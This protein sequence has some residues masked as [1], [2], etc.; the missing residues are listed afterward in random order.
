MSSSITTTPN[1]NTWWKHEKIDITQFVVTE[2]ATHFRLQFRV[3][4]AS[5]TSSGTENCAGWFVDNLHITLSNCELEAPR[6]TLTA[7]FYYNGPSGSP[8]YINTLNNVGPYTINATLKD[9]DTINQNSVLFTYQINSG[10]IDTIANTFTSDQHATSANVH[11]HTILGFWTLPSICYDDTIKYHIYMEDV[12]GNSKH[13]DTF[14]VARH[15]QSNIRTNDC[16]LDS[17]NVSE[18]PHCFLTNAPQPV[19][20]YFTNKSDAAHSQAT[21]NNYQVSLNVTLKVEDE[22]HQVTHNS[23][24]TWN[25][26]LCFD[27]RDTL[28]LGTFLPTHGYNYITIYINSR[29]GQA[30]GY[31]ANDTIR[32]VGYSCDSLLHGDYTVGG[33]NPDFVDMA[34]VHTAL[35][36]CG[37]DGPT[38]FH[39]RPGTYQDFVFRK[40]YSGQSET[41][42]I[43]FQGD[44][45]DNVIVV[46]NTPDTGTTNIYGALT[47][48]HVNDYIF[49]SITFQG[50]NG[51]NSRGVLVRGDKS[52]IL[53]D[54][55]KFTASLINSTESSSFAFGR[56]AASTGQPDDIT[57][58]NCTFSGGNYGLYY[59]GSNTRKN[60][61]TIEN[62]RFLSCYRG[63]YT[64]YCNPII[65]NNHLSQYALSSHQNYSGIVVE[66]VVGA[67][68]DGNTIDSTYDA[69]YGI[70]VKNASAANFYVRNNH[71]K[72]ANSNYGLYIGNCNAANTN[73]YIYNNEIILYPVSQTASY[74]TQIATCNNL[75][76][77]NNSFYLKSDAPVN[78]TAA[79]MIQNSNNT[80]TI[81]SNNILL[82]HCIS[83]DNTDYPL[84][85]NG[86]SPIVGNYNDL[87]SLS[88]VVGYKTVA[89]FN[90]D[91]LE[92]AVNTLTNNISIQ[93]NIANPTESLL[94]TTFS[95]LECDRNANVLTDIRG[96]QRTSLTHM[97]AYANPIDAVDASVVALLVP[98]LGVCPQPTYDITVSIA[99]KGSE[100]LNFASNHATLTLHSDSLNLTQSVNI[101]TGNIAVLQSASQ[102]VATNVAIP[103]NQNID[104]TFIIQTNGDN[105][106]L[107][108]TLKTSFMMEVAKP[109]YEEDFSHGTQQTWDIYQ[110][111]TVGAGNWA[112]Q[113]GTGTN[114][115]IAPVYGTGR[116]Y[117]NSKS[118]AN[119]TESSA[120]MP[121]VDLS[122]S[123]N[124]ILEMWF[125][126]D[127]AASNKT[128][129]GVTVKVS[130]DGVNYTSIHPQ[131]QTATLI[132][133]YQNVTTPTWKLYTYDLN[134]YKSAGCI[135]IAFVAHSQQGN[136]INIDRIRLRNLYDNDISVNQIYTQGE[137]PTEYGMKDVYRALV[138]NEGR[139]AQN[140]VAIYLNVTGATEQY[141]DTLII[142]SIASNNT[143][144][145]ITFPDHLFNSEEVK[146]VEI[147]SRNDENNSNNSIDWRMVTTNNIVNYADTS[148]ASIKI[149]D[150]NNI[151]RPCV[152]YKTSEE[153]AIKAVKYF[154]DQ[155]YIANPENGFRAFV[156]NAQGEIIATSDQIKF[157]DLQ[158]GDW[159][160][161]PINNFALTNMNN[162]FYVGIEMLAK[163]D[164]LCAQ[165]ESP[166]RDSTFYYLENG[167]YVPQ[168]T[169]RFMIGAIVDSPF[170][171]DLAI[172]SLD[173]PTTRCDLGHER[174]TI[175]ITNNGS[176]DILPGTPI[177]YSING[178]TAVNEVLTDT[179]RSHQTTT[180]TFN[181]IF[182]FT[183]NLVNI[184]ST[185]HIIIWC[186]ADSQDRLPYNDTLSIDVVS[187]GKAAMPVVVSNI[188]V[189]YYTEGS[190]NAQLPASISEG[191]IGW[192]TNRG[193][194]QWD[195]LGYTNGTYTTPT[196]FFDTTYYATAHPGFVYSTVVGSGTQS[197]A[198]P[199]V[200]SSKYSRGRILFSESEIGQHGPITSIGFNVKTAATGQNG[201]PIKI[202]IKETSL[203][204][205]P[206]TAS[207]DWDNEIMDA[208][209]VYE[210]SYFFNHTGWD[211]IYLSTPFNYNN[212]N[213]MILTETNCGDYCSNCTNCGQ[214]V[215]GSTGYPSFYQT[216][217]G[218]GYVQYK[219]DKTGNYS[220]Y[221]SRLNMAFNI[222]NLDCGSEKVAIHIHVPDIPTYDVETETLDYPYTSCHL[223]D[224]HVKVTL[225][226]KLNLP[227]PANKIVVHAIF[228][229]QEITQTISDVFAPD[230]TMQ[231]VFD[232]T[233]DFSNS[234]IVNGKTFNYV[235]FTTMNDE[236]IVYGGNDTIRGSF[237]SSYT[238]HMEAEYNYIGFYTQTKDILEPQD[239]QP[240]S[241]IDRYY[242]Y[243]DSAST[244]AL[245]LSPA[246]AR[247]Y[248][249]PVLY[250]TTTYWVMAKTKQGGCE[251]RKVPIHINVF[252]PEYD[253]KTMRLVY[254]QDY[255]C[256][257][258]PSPQLQVEVYN[259]DTTSSSV[260][261]ADTFKLTANFTGTHNVNG[262]SV[263]HVPVSS[264]DNVIATFDNGI[265]IGSTTQN[266]TYNYVIYNDPV[267]SRRG[268]YHIDDTIRGTIHIPAYPNEQPATFTYT[269]PYGRPFN[270]VPPATSPFN[271]FY[272]YENQNDD[273]PFAQGQNF[274][275]DPLY[276]A[277]TYYYRGRIEQT[278]FDTLLTI[279]NGTSHSNSNPFNFA[280][281]HSYA[282]IYYK[283][284]DLE[285]TPGTIDTI[286]VEIYTR[287][288]N[289]EASIPVKIWM[290]NS[291]DA[292]PT[293]NSVSINWRTQTN[294]ATLVF[295]GDL[296]FDATGWYPIPVAGGFDYT[297]DNLILFVEHDCG[298]GSC[299]NNNGISTAPIFKSGT[300][301]K[302]VL[303][304][305]NNTAI[306]TGSKSFSW[307]T[308]R[309]NTR[310]KINHTCITPLMGTIEI[311]TTVP[312]HDVGVIAILA[313][314]TPN[315]NYTANEQVRVTLKNF[316]T[317]AVSNFPV[318]Y[319]LDTLVVSQNYSGSL[320][321]GATATLNFTTRVDLSD[322]YFPTEFKAYT[323]L[324]TDTYR[325]NDTT[326]ILLQK[327]DPNPSR[328]L[329]DTTGADITNV[330][331][332]GINNGTGNFLNYQRGP[333]ENGLY[334]DYTQSVPA[335]EI[336]PGQRY[337]FSMKHSFSNSTAKAVTQTAFIDYNRNGSFEDWERLFQV[338]SLA[339]D[340]IYTQYV[341]IPTDSLSFGETR[342][343]V[344]CVSPSINSNIAP[345][346]YYHNGNSYNYT[347]ETEDY[348]IQISHAK[349]K[350]ISIVN[351]IHPVGAVCPD[352]N[353]TIRLTLKNAGVQALDF[354]AETPLTI[355]TTVRNNNNTNT[356]T[357]TLTNGSLAPSSTMEVT[358]N[359]VDISANGTYTLST[360][361]SYADDEYDQND[362]LSTIAYTN[363]YYPSTNIPYFEDF[364]QNTGG[365]GE[366]PHFTSYWTTFTNHNN[367]CW[368]IVEGTSSNNPQGGATCDHTHGN[369]N[370]NY[371]G[372]YASVTGTSGNNTYITT[373]TSRC[374]NLH[375]QNGYPAELAFY[376]HFFGPTTSE[377]TLQVEIGSGNY[378]VPIATLD[379]T[380]GGQ[381]AASDPWS[382][383]L[384][385]LTNI[386]E[387]AQVRFK[388]THQNKKIDINIDDLNIY[389]GRP[390]IAIEEILV[391]GTDSCLTL[392]NTYHPSLRIKN[393]GTV[394]VHGFD[395][396]CIMSAGF[397]YDTIRGH[398]NATL[399]PD[400]SIDYT[401]D[402]SFVATY[403]SNDIQF[404]FTCYLDLDTNTHNNTKRVL[405][406]T[407]NGIHE[408]LVEGVEL[409]QNE[410]NPATTLTRIN[411]NVPDA[412]KATIT[413]YAATGQ[414]LYSGTQEANIGENYFDINVANF[415]AGLYY[416]SLSFKDAYI[417]KKMVIQK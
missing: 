245:P 158:Q 174:L 202:Y 388:V 122:E 109:Y 384:L 346:E 271:Y 93:P 250:D 206:T 280:N 12:H 54:G 354:S 402:S 27:S 333:G 72:V 395:V 229:G 160:I 106:H 304:Y 373:L 215:S 177:H 34:A 283:A 162:E 251:T 154:Y 286:F 314:T 219:N 376:K 269:A 370:P 39:L 83:S 411:Y 344:I 340:S 414:I 144:T 319:K 19:K 15:N 291:A 323:D 262:N 212:G 105:N 350:D 70:N 278:G 13:L 276:N 242:F 303:G 28:S 9:N 236:D 191:V 90:I 214:N 170:V 180:F 132:K 111:S 324:N 76:I 96:T 363:I 51:N 330:T 146:N 2:G 356:Y 230:T 266:N 140:N 131:E 167:S 88:G 305:S 80:N 339:T 121:V 211:T 53:F 71:V 171:H 186:T 36:Y 268:V 415:A 89:R 133:R 400:E 35:E 56:T 410:P 204:T 8:G 187:L 116:L 18:F 46:N 99:N 279:G 288:T 147:R 78:N 148:A 3:N 81:A 316:G 371:L 200:F 97:G 296:A 123:V 190:L 32:F 172:L 184:D 300:I 126:H 309:W 261:P 224:E 57:I 306:S 289:S 60:D 68:I 292:L 331:F 155:T 151:I 118:F 260:V 357:T 41:N 237:T 406:C 136:D 129:E 94:P 246:T 4:K 37:I 7:P 382:R 275:T 417:T 207:V 43:T 264:L 359:N 412:G 24:H 256:G 119:G 217:K 164:Y 185:Y 208:T 338:N 348:S 145:I 104:L 247:F 127:N 386:D 142:P 139:D 365:P 134:S 14:L 315:S 42:T 403:L 249:T 393:V 110:S 301:S 248:T 327:E 328:P 210:G 377:M 320:A 322:I 74:A 397:D 209:L 243:T 193:Y 169:G 61:L 332:A 341:N 407:D 408:H 86:T 396:E 358:M 49:K 380:D 107:N 218:N 228:N 257:V 360:T 308:T 17:M 355:T 226:N 381:T 6:I 253:L 285:I 22:A 137:T 124:P 11:T 84:Y 385:T 401:F 353:A 47:L 153:L 20:V 232:Q 25:G 59:Y 75:Q 263:I 318:K 183:N 161:I 5:P 334:T 199:F 345:D 378:F 294:G 69:E 416:Y 254:P 295:D 87:S 205:L 325:A 343:R 196:I 77:T 221:A 281:G 342:M 277:T 166:L 413:V 290:Q 349:N 394:A 270:V 241:V 240:T 85:I 383:H 404:Q 58:R 16:R 252:K 361:L 113:E 40:N 152:R 125:A 298:D 29:N 63:I 203:A 50:Q 368:K 95:G 287:N 284:E 108:D 374:L 321:A 369:A 389:N 175:T 227:I 10:S 329:S 100:A 398:V 317:Q 23:Q 115:A 293:A 259:T 390:D 195:F 222:A 114:P 141:H 367:Y 267:N 21:G 326:T 335:G 282:K 239:Q 392:G 102:V 52:N 188:D 165:A 336:I 92:N 62:N 409:G 231:V 91:E 297:G 159:N 255:Q 235:I 44:D 168:T 274:T 67:D 399:L 216:N 273:I 103:T 379:K 302:R 233:F 366:D 181:T 33:S 352:N 244:T 311:N 337:P 30:D 192:Y 225:K 143:E 173:N 234:T 117:F 189:P 362:T 391:P 213:L 55:C 135:H 65:R 375:Y 307:Q 138:R 79:L 182:D 98:S 299:V 405:N 372:R 223:Y 112:F 178:L 31:H 82:N 163:G 64:Y 201:I 130:T 179:L 176:Q 101:N 1:N 150:Y 157:N 238:A 387:C 265:N 48:I 156:S 38:T 73:G 220:N 128:S 66:Y 364:D 351:Y 197:G 258:I 347:G 313:P 149:G 26:A 312:Q 45:V 310:F 198:Q 120:V 272:F 194:E